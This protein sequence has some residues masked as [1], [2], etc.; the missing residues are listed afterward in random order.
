[1]WILRLARSGVDSFSP[2]PYGG[3]FL[4]LPRFA[5]CGSG[6]SRGI[7]RLRSRGECHL[8]FGAEKDDCLW[9]LEIR[10]PGGA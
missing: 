2:T 3:L 10:F 6:N 4:P 8:S 7:H 9:L 1:M 5:G